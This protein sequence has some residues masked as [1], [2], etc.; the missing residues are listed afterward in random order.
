MGSVA[1]VKESDLLKLK[2]LKLSVNSD[3]RDALD[4]Y[5][6]RLRL[7]EEPTG[8]I[9]FGFWF[10]SEEEERSCCSIMFKK[11]NKEWNALLRHCRTVAHVANLFSVDPRQMMD[12]VKEIAEEQSG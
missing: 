6:R 2:A 4:C 5:Y 9:R 11:S 7:Q 12:L 3:M 10:P 1:T 8:K